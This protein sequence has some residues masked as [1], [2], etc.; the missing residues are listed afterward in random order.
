MGVSSLFSYYQD[1]IV[2]SEASPKFET[3]RA[4]PANE[5]QTNA[6][7]RTS[8]TILY[9]IQILR[10]LIFFPPSKNQKNLKIQMR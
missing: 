4:Q 8:T 5:D 7:P 6:Y 10:F 3:L 9:L 1:A 2:E